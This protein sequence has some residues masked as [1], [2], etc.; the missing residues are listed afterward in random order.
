MCCVVSRVLRE[1]P[2]VR[3]LAKRGGVP[4][5]SIPPLGLRTHDGKRDHSL[6]SICLHDG[7]CLS[8]RLEELK[9]DNVTFWILDTVQAD[10]KKG[11]MLPILYHML[12]YKNNITPST[13]H[14][15]WVSLK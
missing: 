8:R 12:S 4:W 14:V 10:S 9:R 15:G 13:K 11:M 2:H 7:R 5:V 3:S 1:D 6:P